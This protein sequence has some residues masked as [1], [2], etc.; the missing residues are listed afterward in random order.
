MNIDLKSERSFTSETEKMLSEL[1][2]M[3]SNRHLT[4]RMIANE[5][6]INSERELTIITEELEMRKICAKM[7]K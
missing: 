2:K 4:T 7:I 5:L 3:Q 6:G 1:Q